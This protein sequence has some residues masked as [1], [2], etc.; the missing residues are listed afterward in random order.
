MTENNIIIYHAGRSESKFLMF[1]K[2][3]L[4]LLQK[5]LYY[6]KELVYFGEAKRRKTPIMAELQFKPTNDVLFK[7]IFVKY[8]ELLRRSVARMLNIAYENIS[9]FEIRNT[10]MPPEEVGKKFC[11][12]DINMAVDGR[13]VNLEVQVE[14]EHDYP[15]RALYHWAREFSSS[16]PAG[17]EG[18]YIKLPK[19]IV[20][21]ILAFQQFDC[22]GY[23]SEFRPLE[24]TRGELLTDKQCLMFFELPKI[25]SEFDEGDELKWWLSFFNAKTEEDMAKILEKG[26]P[27]MAQAVEAYRHVS[28]TEEFR[29]LE[30]L[31]EN[32]RHNEASA[33][34]YARREGRQE[35][36]Q[37][38]RREGELNILAL[39]EKG[40]S[41]AEAKELLGI[42]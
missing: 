39:W 26:G 31:R 16:L 18:E 35:G 34:G 33:L 14:D 15:E 38:G 37:E 6:R 7:M 41:L 29:Q 1:G 9:K 10:E 4:I 36:R 13:L 27:I 28:A 30:R 19:T 3:N 32:T 23:Y 42:K 24:V 40:L 25:P 17:K 22:E 2:K 20:I 5:L 11:R 21:S 12:L 8:P